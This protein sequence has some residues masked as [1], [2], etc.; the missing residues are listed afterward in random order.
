MPPHGDRGAG[1]FR[2]RF[3]F[4]PQ[5]R[6]QEGNLFVG[7]L[8]LHDEIDDVGHCVQREIL[9]SRQLAQHGGDRGRHGKAFL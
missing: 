8:A 5:G 1:D 9:A 6:E 3:A 4:D 2:R 7:K